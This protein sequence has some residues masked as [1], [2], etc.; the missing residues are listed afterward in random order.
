MR[1]W[2]TSGGCKVIQLMSGRCNVFM[3][4]NGDKNILIDTGRKNSWD[5]L[6]A[7]IEETNVTHFDALILTHTHFDHVEN[8]SKV[9]EKYKTQVIVH[10]SEGDFLKRG[11]SPLPQGT[12]L[13]TRFLISHFGDRL[14][15]VFKYDECDFDI[16]VD[17]KFDLSSFGFNAYVLHTPGH[18]CGSLSVIVDDEI[19]IVGDAMLG[20]YVGTVFPPFADN[21]SQMIESWRILLD[22][23]CHTF[24]PAH[25]TANSRELL[26]KCYESR[27]NS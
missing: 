9:K 22:T 25:G 20:V 14:Q 11:D 23:G 6:S 4:S 18:S 17:S 3:L 10:Q 19:A 7:Q 27:V 13:P 8:A 21:V 26:Q 2:K 16:L 5:K 12:I 24:L 15:P 1:T